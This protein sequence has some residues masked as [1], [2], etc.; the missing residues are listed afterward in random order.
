ME[1]IFI[2]IEFADDKPRAVSTG[3]GARLLITLRR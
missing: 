3:Y 1:R 2:C